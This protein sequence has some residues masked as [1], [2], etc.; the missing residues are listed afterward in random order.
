MPTDKTSIDV[1]KLLVK[2]GVVALLAN[3]AYHIGVEYLTYVKFEDDVRD[4]AIFK[5]KT[6][7]ELTTRMLALA[8]H[9]EIPLDEENVNIER[10]GRVVRIDG[11]YDKPIELLPNYRYPW[12]FGLSMDVNSQ[13]PLAANSSR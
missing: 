4:A 13:V 9:Y 10:D 2:L 11:W 12:H 1:V 8:Q 3:A 7:A 6:D 5:A